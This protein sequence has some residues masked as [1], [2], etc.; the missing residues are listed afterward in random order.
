MNGWV[1]GF[2][3]FC[4]VWDIRESLICEFACWSTL[5]FDWQPILSW[6]VN[7]YWVLIVNQYWV[8]LLTNIEFWLLTNIT[9]RDVCCR[10]LEQGQ[11]GAN[12]ICGAVSTTIC[13]WI[14]YKTIIA[15]IC[16]C[17]SSACLSIIIHQICHN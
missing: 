2:W 11:K 14:V 10:V 3:R 13:T 8:G 4:I 9:R 12:T 7:Q 15:A 5:S 1:L 16:Y 17:L 6:I